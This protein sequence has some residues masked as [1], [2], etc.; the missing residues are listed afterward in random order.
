MTI[1]NSFRVRVNKDSG[2]IKQI[3]RS[4]IAQPEVRPVKRTI[5]WYEDKK[6]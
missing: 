5:K 4:T 3:S 1:M 2:I 6:K